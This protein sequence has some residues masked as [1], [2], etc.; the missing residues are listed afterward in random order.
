MDNVSIDAWKALHDAIMEDDVE[1]V[2]GLLQE[3]RERNMN[4]AA[5]GA[6]INRT[7]TLSDLTDN[8]AIK[9]LLRQESGNMIQEAGSKK[10]GRRATK[11]HAKKRRATKRR[12]A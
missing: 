2:E 1:G 7:V 6:I 5:V 8:D 10:R 11:R 9:D 3:M 4:N 12:T